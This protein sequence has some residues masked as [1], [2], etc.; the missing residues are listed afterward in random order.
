MF[1]K[2]LIANRGEIAIR[3]MRA[4]RE[5]GIS[6]VAVY[7][8]A[9]K[10]A[11]HVREADEAVCIGSAQPAASYLNMQNIVSAALLTG[12][13]AIHPGYGFLSESEEFAQLCEECHLTFIGPK[14][15]TISLMGNKANARMT[16]QQNHVP[17]IPGS[18]GF[19]QNSQEAL[20][21][22]QEVGFP[23]M[24]K[25]AAGGG[26]KGIRKVTC[27]EDLADAFLQAQEE[28]Q[29]SFGDNRM[30][31]EKVISPAKHI[32]VQ[33]LADQNGHAVALPER[34]CSLQ[35]RQ[36]KV[37]EE[38]PCSVIQDDERQNLQEVALRAVKAI[39]YENVGTIEFLMDPQHNFYFMEMNTRIQVEHSIT[40]EVSQVDLIKEQIN[41]AAGQN[42]SL[43]QAD[44]RIHGTAI[45]ARI[46]AEDPLHGFRPQAGH[47]QQMTLPGGLG[48]RLESGVTS[49][50]NVS[51]FYDSMIIKI[52]AHATNRKLVL[53][54]IIDALNEFEIQGLTTNREFLV[55][56]LKQPIVQQ[57]EY[58]TNY[59]DKE[60]LPLYTMQADVSEEAD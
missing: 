29:L 42:L 5:L 38:T 18:E 39:N 28:A 3:V 44:V 24:I 41:I 56:L 22:A 19:V 8:T 6:S 34:D 13:Q 53:R 12:A 37:I 51:P 46:N 32:E 15:Q 7:S 58:L 55:A 11:Q 17:V 57:G 14:S 59:I 36:Q 25:A 48:I 30:Y 1:D 21:I 43:T 23:V 60:F 50:D 45:E 10:D 4:L 54:R 40:E 47:I 2:V 49:G 33:V 31:L 20:Q 9:D 26:G 52:I 35:R 16:M 27:A